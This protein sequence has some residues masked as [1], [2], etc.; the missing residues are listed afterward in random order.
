[1]KIKQTNI[2][3]GGVLCLIFKQINISNISKLDVFQDIYFA[4]SFLLN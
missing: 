4:L 1:M 2:G 3:H